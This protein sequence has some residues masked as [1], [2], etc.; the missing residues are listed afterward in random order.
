VLLLK[1]LKTDPKLHS[2]KDNAKFHSAFSAT[3]LSYDMHFPQK[4]GV[5]ENF[6]NLGEFQEDF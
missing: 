6:E 1:M 4:W 5:I 2:C 3:T